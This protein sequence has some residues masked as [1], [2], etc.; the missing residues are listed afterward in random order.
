MRRGY[1]LALVVTLSAFLGIAGAVM[2]ERYATQRLSLKRQMD[3][4]QE[5]HGTRGIQEVFMMWMRS[6][7]SESLGKQARQNPHVLDIEL[8]DGTTLSLFLHDGQGTLLS[9]PGSLSGTER[10]DAEALLN[11][12]RQ[13]PDLAVRQDLFRRA[14]PAA[15]S[16][17][18]APEE[19][20]RVVARHLTDSPA[21]ADRLLEG[22][23]RRRADGEFNTAE[24]SDCANE[25]DLSREARVALGRLLASEPSLWRVVVELRHPRVWNP[26]GE[27]LSKYEGL[28]Y[29]DS[30]ASRP[31][32]ASGTEA[33]RQSTP[34]IEWRR[35]E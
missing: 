19:V 14:G 11:L 23:L 35:L 9:E 28:F 6:M 10:S 15:I 20:L 29:L 31:G 1:A 26:D 17:V 34:F 8:A 30:A 25:A 33:M 27:L 21:Q 22:I 18:E 4:Y 24:S 2:L 12:A 3:R 5:L 32:R 7:S 16:V 13:D